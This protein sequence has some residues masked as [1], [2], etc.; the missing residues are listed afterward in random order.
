MVRGT[1]GACSD[2]KVLRI[3]RAIFAPDALTLDEWLVFGR[4]G[5]LAA[6][7]AARASSFLLST[8]RRPSISR[9]RSPAFSSSERAASFICSHLL[10]AP[11]AQHE[12]LDTQHKD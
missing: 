9:W 6:R 10:F 3:S 8:A 1:Y 2:G 11:V 7:S 5:P 4:P 12:V